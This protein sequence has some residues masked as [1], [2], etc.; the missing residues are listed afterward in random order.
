[1]DEN[2][3][4]GDSAFEDRIRSL[5]DSGA[6]TRGVSAPSVIAGARGRRARRRG[7]A[8]GSS[9]AVLGIAAG[10]VMLHGHGGVPATAGGGQAAGITE[11]AKTTEGSG[12]TTTGKTTETS[13]PAAASSPTP[14]PETCSASVTG[15]VP[16]TTSVTV[17]GLDFEQISGVT[18]GIPWSEQV[19]AFPTWQ[20]WL[21][22]RKTQT[23]PPVPSTASHVLGPPVL[24]RRAGA[25]PTV[26]PADAAYQFT[27]TS[28]PHYSFVFS[29]SSMG[30]SFG[31]PKALLANMWALPSVDH[32]CL[33]FAHHAEFEPVYRLQTGGFAPIGYRADDPPQAVIG[34]DA[35]GR[36]VGM[37]TGATGLLPPDGK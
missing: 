26:H 27:M 17:D 20:A 15:A 3:D 2:H 6:V 14:A 37:G 9:L 10:A 35:A 31:S 19:H 32:L 11:I 22:W 16:A 24:I 12:T 7:A 8:A 21:D 13:T 23:D 4:D 30:G 29:G 28:V 5:L 18:A 36:V 33:Q 34:Y 1:M 25:T